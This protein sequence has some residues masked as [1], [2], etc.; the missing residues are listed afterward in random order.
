MEILDVYAA[1]QVTGGVNEQFFASS[2]TGGAQGSLAATGT[3]SG[4]GSALGLAA[5]ASFSIGYG[6]ETAP[7]A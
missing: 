7:G 2:G 4:A 5:A 1:G 3:L 6:V